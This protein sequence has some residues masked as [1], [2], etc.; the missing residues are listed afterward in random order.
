MTTPHKLYPHITGLR[1]DEG[2]NAATLAIA[3]VL[4]PSPH[5]PDAGRII[6]GSPETSEAELG[7][8]CSGPEAAVQ[9]AETLL[10]AAADVDAALDAIPPVRLTAEYPF[11]CACCGRTVQPG[12]AIAVFGGAR[13]GASMHWGP[14]PFTERVIAVTWHDGSQRPVRALVYGLWALHMKLLPNGR[15]LPDAWSVTHVPTGRQVT[16]GL[17]SFTRREAWRIVEALG[18]RCSSARFEHAG[19]GSDLAREIAAVAEEVLCG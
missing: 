2:E 11:P 10:E 1:G 16:A 14:C 6:V 12:E 4:D 7:G 5:Y 13:G 18:A 19:P 15:G 9:L 3:A 17:S 8:W